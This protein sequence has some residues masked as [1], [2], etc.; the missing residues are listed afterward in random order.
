[1]ETFSEDVFEFREARIV[2]TDKGLEFGSWWVGMRK[3][4]MG[5]LIVMRD[6]G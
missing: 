5:N 6:R 2:G 4:G 3:D 1:M